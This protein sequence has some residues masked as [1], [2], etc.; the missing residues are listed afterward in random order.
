[1]QL[2]HLRDDERTTAA[3]ARSQTEFRRQVQ[4]L[5]V[6]ELN[7]KSQAIK[8]LSRQIPSPKI[9]YWRLH[10]WVLVLLWSDCNYAMILPHWK[11]NICKFLFLFSSFMFFFK[12]VH[13]WET[14]Y[15]REDLHFERDVRC[16]KDTAIFKVFEF[17]KTEGLLKHGMHFILRYWY[18]KNMSS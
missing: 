18:R 10:S 14:G 3:V 12:R 1:M 2:Q 6:A 17:L 16:F 11:K 4:V 9:W 7:K 5:W 13:S 8:A 15:F